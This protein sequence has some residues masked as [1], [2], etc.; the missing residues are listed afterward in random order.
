MLGTSHTSNKTESIYDNR[1]Q[2][3]GGLGN[4]KFQKK[5][6]ESYK[7][8]V[9]SNMDGY[10]EPTI[11]QKKLPLKPKPV[12][13]APMTPQLSS[14]EGYKEEGNNDLVIHSR[15]Y[16]NRNTFD[17]LAEQKA[18]IKSEKKVKQMKLT[19]NYVE[20][21]KSQLSDKY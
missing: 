9:N 13:K 18:E 14:S 7:S 19:K 17:E 8:N 6:T 4:I 11:E 21:D 20:K 1:K 16:Q 12:K 5:T 10:D 15:Q 3:S 2:E